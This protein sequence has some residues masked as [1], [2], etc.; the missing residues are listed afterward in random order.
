MT[1]HIPLENFEIVLG[2]VHI[3]IERFRTAGF[4][5][6]EVLVS[7]QGQ[8]VHTS[9]NRFLIRETPKELKKWSCKCISSSPDEASSALPTG[10][11]PSGRVNF[12]FDSP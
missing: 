5:G 10:S 9:E 4:D 6:V 2:D 11:P 3:H 7:S 1:M 8:V 12:P